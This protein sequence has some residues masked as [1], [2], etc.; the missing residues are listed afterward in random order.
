ARLLGVMWE[1]DGMAQEKRDDD[2]RA[3]TEQ[4]GDA[5]PAATPAKKTVRRVVRQTAPQK[6]RVTLGRGLTSGEEQRQ[7][8]NRQSQNRQSRQQQPRRPNRSRSNN[9]TKTTFSAV[10]AASTHLAQRART[11]TGDAAGATRSRMDRARWALVNTTP[12][13]TAA[14]LAGLFSGLLTVLVGWGFTHLF[15]WI[16][17]TSTGGHT[18]GKITVAAMLIIAFAAGQ[19]LMRSLHVAHSSLTSLT[20]IC[21]TLAVTLAFLLD[22]VTGVWVW[23]II[24]A[25]A[26]VSFAVMQA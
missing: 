4:P 2:N 26:A 23:L 18:W 16:R 3:G 8:Q 22:L 14:A 1:T 20:G 6:P 7:S 13:P 17:G 24:P 9:K 21:V 11:A 12:K 5:S 19:Q 25:V 15:S 10:S